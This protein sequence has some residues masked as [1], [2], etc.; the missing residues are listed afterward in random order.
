MA[1]HFNVWSNQKQ[2]FPHKLS[3]HM[4]NAWLLFLILAALEKFSKLLCDIYVQ[5]FM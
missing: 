2:Y 5:Q 3:S 1:Q 4:D